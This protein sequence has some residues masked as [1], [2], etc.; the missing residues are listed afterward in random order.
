MFFQ[1]V[2]LTWSYTFTTRKRVSN[3]RYFGHSILVPEL[4]L[5]RPSLKVGTF[6]IDFKNRCQNY[7]LHR[8]WLKQ[9]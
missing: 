2:T 3:I 5:K 6:N 8:F 7:Y 4:M 1:V 9:M